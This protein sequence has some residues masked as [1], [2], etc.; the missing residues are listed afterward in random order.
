VQTGFVYDG[1]NF[2]QELNGAT[3]TA[4]LVTGGIDELFA[5]K[6]GA[7]ASY[8]LTD[9]LGSV[10]GLTDASG[11]LQTQ[12]SYEPY[13]KATRSGAGTTNSQTYTG[14]EDDGTGL[15]YYRARFYAPTLSRFIAEDPQELISDWSNPYRYAVDS[16]INVIDPTGEV[17]IFTALGIAGGAYAAEQVGGR[18]WMASL[19]HR[20]ANQAAAA[21]NAAIQAC[22]TYPQGGACNSIDFFRGQLLRCT[23]SFTDNA[24]H[25]V[26]GKGPGA[27]SVARSV[28]DLIRK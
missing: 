26:E 25:V 7:T 9:A 28:K 6:E 27:P 11:A 5:R 3:V 13:G 4:N 17:G 16:P 24:G 21:L 20:N 10:I 19:D 15:Y 2:V 1:E 8:P 12:Y 23:A 14:R 22:Q 18:I